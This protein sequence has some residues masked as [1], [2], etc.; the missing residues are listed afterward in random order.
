VIQKAGMAS[1]TMITTIFLFHLLLNLFF[2]LQTAFLTLRTRLYV[3]QIFGLP[4]VATQWLRAVQS[5]ERTI[6]YR[7]YRLHVIV[8][9]NRESL[10]SQ[11]TNYVRIEAQLR[12]TARCTPLSSKMEAKARRNG[13]L[14]LYEAITKVIES[15]VRPRRSS[16]ARKVLKKSL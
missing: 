13:N 3:L 10:Y 7:K 1:A 16:Y 15:S 8:M 14:L 5:P 2:H 6:L 9:A 4:I 12:L 11:S